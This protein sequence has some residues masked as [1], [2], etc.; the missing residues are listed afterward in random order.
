M[1]FCKTSS[2]GPNNLLKLFLCDFWAILI[3]YL[4]K[5]FSASSIF[6]IFINKQAKNIFIGNYLCLK[7]FYNY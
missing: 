1:L 6:P 4:S 7:Q 2:I 3:F 5:I